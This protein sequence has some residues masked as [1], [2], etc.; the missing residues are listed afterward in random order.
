MCV[1]RPSGTRITDSIYLYGEYDYA[2]SDKI[3][4]PWAIDAALDGY[5][6]DSY[7]GRGFNSC[8]SVA[9]DLVKKKS[10]RYSKRA[11]GMT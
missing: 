5:G 2:Y 4:I 3:R 11:K 1:T 7:R 6:E 10:W 9:R 8:Q